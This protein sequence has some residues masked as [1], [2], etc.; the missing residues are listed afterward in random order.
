M[1]ATCLLKSYQDCYM[2]M[3]PG[4]FGGFWGG[5]GSEGLEQVW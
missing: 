5:G 1:K 2:L 3:W 4:L